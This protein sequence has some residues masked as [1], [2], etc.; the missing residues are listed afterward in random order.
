M[1]VSFPGEPGPVE[2][3]GKPCEFRYSWRAVTS[4]PAEPKERL[5]VNISVVVAVVVAL[6]LETGAVL[7]FEA[8]A[9]RDADRE[10]FNDAL[11]SGPRMPT[12]SR[13]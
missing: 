13:P 9:G 6:G 2:A 10:P 8:E 7:P 5:R 1:V 11:V 4:D 3:I 12:A